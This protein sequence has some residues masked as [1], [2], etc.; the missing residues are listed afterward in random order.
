M[1]IHGGSAEGQDATATALEARGLIHAAGSF[2]GV[3]A[4]ISSGSVILEYDGAV[5]GSATANT[6]T[7]TPTTANTDLVVVITYTNTVL[8]TET[9]SVKCE[10][11]VVPYPTG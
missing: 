11:A 7:A 10:Y 4:V 8:A 5:Q 6:G 2:D 1:I 3:D 9:L